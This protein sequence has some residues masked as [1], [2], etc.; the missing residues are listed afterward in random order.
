LLKQPLLFGTFGTNCL[1]STTWDFANCTARPKTW[2][3]PLKDAQA[4][5]DDAV[6]EAF[7]MSKGKDAIQF[8]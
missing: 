4:K 3:H 7:G 5:L 1:K 8:C 2:S 6:R